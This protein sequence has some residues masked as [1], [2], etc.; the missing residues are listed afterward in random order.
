VGVNVHP[1]RDLVRNPQ[2]FDALF[3]DKGLRTSE[4]FQEAYKYARK[5]GQA[6]A[7][8]G[9]GGGFMK[10]LMEQRIC[11]SIHAG[12]NTAKMMLEGRTV[13]VEYDEEEYESIVVE[14]REE[15]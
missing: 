9:K 5:F 4:D 1:D 2:W 7:R 10:N 8:Q 11:S 6:L 15:L 3:E 12:L 14:G 13:P